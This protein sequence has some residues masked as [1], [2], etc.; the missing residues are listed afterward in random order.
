MPLSFL[1]E[2]AALNTIL[3]TP[4]AG[5]TQASIELS[6]SH[7]EI[8]GEANAQFTETTSTQ[9][10][11]ANEPDFALGAN[12]VY[13]M[14]GRYDTQATKFL[15]INWI[16]HQYQ[17][18]FD[19]FDQLGDICNVFPTQFLDPSMNLGQPAQ[20]DFGPSVA[21]EQQSAT[22]QPSQEVRSLLSDPGS[23][24]SRDSHGSGSFFY[25][26]GDGS[27]ASLRPGFHDVT[28]DQSRAYS[29]HERDLA[30]FATAE[31]PIQL[32]QSLRSNMQSEF[33]DV[34]HNKPPSF[35][36]VSSWV[37]LY[38]KQ[39]HPTFSFLRRPKFWDKD[40]DWVLLL[41]TIAVGTSLSHTFDAER[42]RRPL[43]KILQQAVSHRFAI[44]R[45]QQD[46]RTDWISPTP[47]QSFVSESKSSDLTT[48]Q[49]MV[50]S[51]LCLIHGARNDEISFAM[52]ERLK[53]V[54]A[55][56]SMHLLSKPS[57][58]NLF[59][60]RCDPEA[61]CRAWY[62][63]QSFARIGLMIWLLD[64][65]IVCEFHCQPLLQLADVM[66][67]LPC[68]ETVWDNQTID[69]EV[70]KSIKSVT[71]LDALE[72]L[73]MEKKL[74]AKMSEFSK[75]ILIYGICRRTKE[76][77]LRSQSQLM[78]WTPSATI[79]SR[80][81]VYERGETWPPSSNLLSQWRNSACD[82]LD[83]LH[84]SA[85]STA[86]AHWG[87]EH[88]TLF[89]LHLSRLLILAPLRHIQTLATP[90]PSQDVINQTGIDKHAK[91][92]EFVLR[93]YL[94]DQYKARLSVV[95]AGAL[96][97]H[98]RRYST[99]IFLEPYAIYVATLVL[100]AYSTALQFCQSRGSELPILDNNGSPATSNTPG[101]NPPTHAYSDATDQDLTDIMSVVVYLDR[102]IDDEL[103]QTYIRWGAKMT[104]CLSRVGD[105]ASPSAPAK[106]L[107]EAFRLLSLERNSEA[108]DY[109]MN[110]SSTSSSGE[111][112]WGVRSSFAKSL[113]SLIRATQEHRY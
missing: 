35:Q 69:P 41:A 103:V 16:A 26:D 92:R 73:Y 105:I 8:I 13:D 85:N 72:L 50:L 7:S 25:I 80:T 52:A 67:P 109:S 20:E 76:V 68:S 106:I 5:T 4:I 31:V 22:D 15:S 112:V 14:S 74:V 86:L 10:P 75:L 57:N 19:P 3:E 11:T 6:N 40:S 70:L 88:P 17:T 64:F 113:D 45:G 84:W 107:K 44:M 9:Q 108:R 34:I 46:G 59:D 98:C 65:M 60:P 36:Q 43:M 91:S 78:N 111:L 99:R 110:E 51:M 94:Q 95:H 100:W 48:L 37:D 30:S 12:M 97:W 83:I 47:E 18:S 62:Q 77:C 79:E 29:H 38:F 28:P 81:E 71:V 55:C 87:W 53:L 54:D 58:H 89:H 49:A 39:F 33:N 61:Q 1:A 63:Q 27:R 104:A 101:S 90:S 56:H 23:V 42:Y 82:C 96:L 24:I 66:V 32:Y 2:A 93:W 102:P 21:I